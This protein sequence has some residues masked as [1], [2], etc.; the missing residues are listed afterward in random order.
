MPLAFLSGQ[1]KAYDSSGRAQ[2]WE[3]RLS[4]GLKKWQATLQL[5]I[6]AS[7]QQNIQRAVVFRGLGNINPVERSMY[8]KRVHVFFH[9]KAWMVEDINMKLMNGKKKEKRNS[10]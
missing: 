9:R 3:S 1:E 5:C 4:C 7:G 10:F 6:R 2:I 8:D